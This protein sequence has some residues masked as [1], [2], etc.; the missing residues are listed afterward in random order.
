VTDDIHGRLAAR[1]QTAD[2]MWQVGGHDDVVAVE[3]EDH[4]TGLQPT[5]ITRATRHDLSHQRTG[6]TFQTE[7][8]GQVLVDLLNH[9]AQPATAYCAVTLQ[10]L[11]H[12]HGHIHRDGE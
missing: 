9:H 1:A 4:V 12:I 6:G 7:G 10:L 2:S 11:D 8:F 5:L 3:L